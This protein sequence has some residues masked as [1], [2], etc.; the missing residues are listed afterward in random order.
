MKLYS[1]IGPNPRMVRI[2]M[3]ERGATAELVKIDLM[4]AENR[5]ESFLQKNPAGQLPAL[6]LDDGTVLSEITAIC[7]YIDE[8][9]PGSSLIGA[10]P[11]QRA[12]TRMWTRRIDLNI[13][14]PMIRGFRYS[15][16]LQMF[17]SRVRCIPEAADGLKAIAREQLAWLDGLIEG[18]DFIC[19]DRLSMADIFL[20]AFLEFGKQVG[21]PFDPD[22]STIPDWFERMAARPSTGRKA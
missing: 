5:G 4:R 20:F 9:T 11:E 7:E 10:T 22:L 13:V 12:E 2:F 19:G 14:E 17:E 3:A 15:D 16:G 8:T 18:R 1:S 6:E 21:Q